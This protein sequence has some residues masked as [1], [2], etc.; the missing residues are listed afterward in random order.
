LLY[1]GKTK[2]PGSLIREAL[3]QGESDL[4]YAYW[5][6]TTKRVDYELEIDLLDIIGNKR[7][8]MPSKPYAASASGDFLVIAETLM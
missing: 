8:K 2:K 5:Q 7:V 1:A 4:A 6:Q 3:R